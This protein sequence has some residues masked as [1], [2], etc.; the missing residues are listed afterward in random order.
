VVGGTVV[1]AEGGIDADILAG[2]AIKLTVIGGDIEGSIIA[3][4]AVKG[5]SAKVMRV[6]NG[7]EVTPYGGHLLSNP[8]SGGAASWVTLHPEYI[9][10]KKPVLGN[11]FGSLGVRGMFYAGYADDAVT[12]PTFASGLL[13]V[14]TLPDETIY[15]IAYIS[16][17]S[18]GPVL[19]GDI[20]ALGRTFFVY[21]D[22]DQ[23]DQ[24]P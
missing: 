20:H 23:E 4:G 5:A 22:E 16:S 7:S 21:T 8:I 18:V 1:V 19:K 13:G 12:S 3:R 17:K 24:Q 9:G 10:A 6:K 15:G 14:G 11:M 2:D